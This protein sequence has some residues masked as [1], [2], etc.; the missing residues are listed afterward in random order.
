MYTKVC[1]LR[2]LATTDFHG[3]AEAFRKTALKARQN[4]ADVVVV[5]GDV[6]HFGSL[7]Q[8][9]ELLSFLHATQCPVLYVPGNCDPAAL[10][11]EEIEK[12]EC[13]HGKCKEI[14]NINFLGVGGSSPTPFDTPFE[15]TETEIAHILEQSFDS[16]QTKRQTI[17]VSHSPPKNTKVDLTFTGEHAGSTSVRK[18]IEKTNPSLVLCG[19]IHEATGTDKINNTTIT[20]PGPAR[21][22]HCALIHINTH[23]KIK[24]NNL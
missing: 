24:L 22:G 19:H 7:Q 21:H 14:D 12:I 6:T 2:I 5:C 3:N 11:K 17:L 9:K 4:R 8:A 13:I 10:A 20:N 23:K 1:C 18:F 15:L 16:C